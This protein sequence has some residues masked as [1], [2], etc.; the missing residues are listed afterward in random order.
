VRHDGGVD[1]ER[2]ASRR[3]GEGAPS[4]PVSALRSTVLVVAALNAAAFVVE[5]A[6]A[7]AIG[8]VSLL[9]DSVDFL[10][11]TAV[12]L[13]IALAL[14]WSL[15]ARARVGRLLAVVILLPALAVIVQLVLKIGEPEAPAVL[16]L[17]LTALGAAAVNL[18][19]GLLLARS[20]TAHREAETAKAHRG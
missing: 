6:V 13:L 1:D 7:L 9:A 10:E 16:P 14:G 20:P 5:G 11:D 12:N 2:G 17:V 8:S 18:A 15:A 19:A 3:A 4:I